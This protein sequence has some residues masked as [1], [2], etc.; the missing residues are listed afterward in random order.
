MIVNFWNR[1]RRDLKSHQY[2]AA[3]H[4]RTQIIMLGLPIILLRAIADIKSSMNSTTKTKLF[5]GKAYRST[6]PYLSNL[7]SSEKFWVTRNLIMKTWNF[8][9]SL[10]YRWRKSDLHHDSR[11][12]PRIWPLCL[13]DNL[14]WWLL[15]NTRKVTIWTTNPE[16]AKHHIIKWDLKA[17]TTKT[18]ITSSQ[19]QIMTL[20]NKGLTLMTILAYR[21]RRILKLMRSRI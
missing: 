18:L 20:L 14:L 9:L 12:P 4:I 21:G 7:I 19:T 3:N 5:P 16:I 11:E 15:P 6:S 8:A 10:A 17:V 1:S 2:K 13:K